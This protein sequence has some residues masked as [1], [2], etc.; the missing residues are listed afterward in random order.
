LDFLYPPLHSLYRDFSKFF[1][2]KLGIPRELPTAKWVEALRN[3]ETIEDPDERKAEALTIYRRANRD[4]RPKFG[5]EVQ[6]PD[7][8]ETFQTE[9]VY[10]NQRGELVPNDEYLFANDAPTIAALFEDEEDISFIAVP[11]LEVPRL[12]RLLDAAE[13]SRLS[14]SITLEVS[15]ADSGVVDENLTARVRS[16]VHYFARILYVKRPDAFE[17]AL[18]DGRFASL[19]EFNV[20]EV[21]QVEMAV[22]LGDYSRETATDIALSEDR[23]LYRSGARSVKDMLA[24]ELSRFLGVS[25]DLADTFAR[26]LMESDA[27]SIED[28]LRVRSIGALPADLLEA[29][30]RS[31]G[32]T[33]DVDEADGADGE[34]VEPPDGEQEATSEEE[35]SV[36]VREAEQSAG[37]GEL[38]KGGGLAFSP[39]PATTPSGGSAVRGAVPGR[40]GTPNPKAGTDPA[41]VPSSGAPP[42]RLSPTGKEQNHMASQF[43][44]QVVRQHGRKA[45][46]G[47]M[48]TPMLHATVKQV[49]KTLGCHR[50]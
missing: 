2:D 24:A 29:L 15:N 5:R 20:A 41:S 49:H 33:A 22:S 28:F 8:V 43:P 38:P 50:R 19:R 25:S 3:L 7:W 18:A 36:A 26:V 23:V 37:G 48:N 35:P 16:S 44:P 47:Q 39:T 31:A 46:R 14:E 27:D 40:P 10:I 11:D 17:Q 12:S 34:S 9:A 32:P 45:T 30:D 4:L 21:P 6:A 1:V 13:V 42:Q